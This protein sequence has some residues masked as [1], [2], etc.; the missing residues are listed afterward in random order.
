MA[1]RKV[2]EEFREEM[3]SPNLSL[4][5]QPTTRKSE[6]PGLGP[7]LGPERGEGVGEEAKEDES[8]LTFANTLSSF[9]TDQCKESTN[10]SDKRTII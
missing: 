5:S 4:V 9:S 6:G 3:W 10:E 2:N 7:G 1:I 8:M